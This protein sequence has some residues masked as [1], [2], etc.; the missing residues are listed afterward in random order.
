MQAAEQLDGPFALGD[1]GEHVGEADAVGVDDERHRAARG[2]AGR[3][4]QQVGYFLHLLARQLRRGLGNV[5]DLGIGRHLG[6]DEL[7]CGGG[8]LLGGDGAARHDH[9][10]AMKRGN[11]HVQRHAGTVPGHQ[12]AG[13]S[14]GWP[15]T[16]ARCGGYT[17]W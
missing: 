10:Q 12:I 16:S 15:K 7:P 14:A 5:D 13:N 3:A 4:A 8:N 9:H 6:L 17:A 11:V 2:V 1:V